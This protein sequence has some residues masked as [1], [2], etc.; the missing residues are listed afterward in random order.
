MVATCRNTHLCILTSFVTC[1]YREQKGKL[2]GH[3]SHT[4]SPLLVRGHVYTY[5]GC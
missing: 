3:K 4:C 5:Q 2:D 1:H